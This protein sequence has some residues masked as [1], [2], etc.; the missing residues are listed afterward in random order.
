MKEGGNLVL[1]S[2]LAPIHEGQL[3]VPLAQGAQVEVGLAPKDEGFVVGRP[4]AKVLEG[5]APS[6]G[7]PY[8]RSSGGVVSCVPVES[9]PNAFNSAIS[10]Q[11]IM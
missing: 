7:H 6:G 11:Q 4:V 3:L 5:L 2:A 1:P 10:M 8:R 9:Y